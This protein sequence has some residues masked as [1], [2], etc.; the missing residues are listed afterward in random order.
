M[1]PLTLSI[2]AVERDTGLSKDTLR[3][4]ERRYGFPTPER[5]AVGERAYSLDQVEKLLSFLHFRNLGTAVG[6]LEPYCIVRLSS[7][8]L[9]PSKRKKNQ[10][11]RYSDKSD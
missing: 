2:S 7:W 6:G 3:V 9:V 5:D 8:S 11:K 1:R 4:W 10:W